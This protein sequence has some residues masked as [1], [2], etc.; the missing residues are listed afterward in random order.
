MNRSLRI[1]IYAISSLFWLGLLVALM[2]GA[3]GS[4]HPQQ[5]APLLGLAIAVE[6][7]GVWETSCA[8]NAQQSTQ[9]PPNDTTA[10]RD[11]SR[12]PAAIRVRRRTAS[13]VRT[14]T[15]T[16][17]IARATVARFAS[18]RPIESRSV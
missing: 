13:V 11:H 1:Y 12:C 5:L 18:V 10:R 9:A 7:I 17:S 2:T 3:L 16:A 14:R 8:P 15:A 6:A 4:L